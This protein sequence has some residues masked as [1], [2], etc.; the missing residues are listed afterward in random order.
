MLLVGLYVF[1]DCRIAWVAIQSSSEKCSEFRRIFGTLWE[2][3]D[4]IKIGKSSQKLFPKPFRNVKS[5]VYLL[6]LIAF[7]AVL[8][9]NL[10]RFLGRI[11]G[12]IFRV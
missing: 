9:L 7:C 1:G 4:S 8:Y 11:F 3:H 5:K 12:R 6:Q 2:V 10:G